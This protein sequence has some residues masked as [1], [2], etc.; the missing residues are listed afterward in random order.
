LVGIHINHPGDDRYINNIFAGAGPSFNP[1]WGGMDQQQLDQVPFDMEGNLY[2]NGAVPPVFD[3]HPV[4]LADVK[5]PFRL[6]N[7]DGLVEWSVD[8]AWRSDPSRAIV[9]AKRL[10]IAQ[11]PG[12]PFELPDGSPVKVDRDFSGVVRTP[13]NTMPGPV[14]TSGSGRFQWNFHRN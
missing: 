9:T 7:A 14:E 12:L 8:P 1:G 10:G 13:D 4:V 3:Q 11:V 6:V 2:L 5:P